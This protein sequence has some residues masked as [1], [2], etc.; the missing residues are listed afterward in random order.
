VTSY[1]SLATTTEVADLVIA[2]GD[3]QGTDLPTSAGALVGH[4][5]V[6]QPL[7]TV[8]ITINA[9]A[10]DPAY[11]AT[12]ANAWVKALAEMVK[13]IDGP[14]KAAGGAGTDSTAEPPQGSTWCR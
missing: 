2:G 5:S 11:A 4:V 1:V 13:Q 12:L 9:R 7:D 8:L 14:K 3:L 6:E 10:S